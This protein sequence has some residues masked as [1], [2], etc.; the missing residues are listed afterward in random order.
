[1]LPVLVGNASANFIRN[2]WTSTVIFCGRF[3]DEAQTFSE[4]ECENESRGHWYYRQI[5]GSAN[6][7]GSR[8]LHI[9]SGHL[10]LQVEHHLFPDI[11]AHR[12]VEMAPLVEATA[13]KHG[14]PYNKKPFWTQY[15]T[16]VKRILQHSVPE[17][18]FGP[19]S[20]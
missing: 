2:I 13:R 7:D 15:K 4:E 14:I 6:F 10:S 19:V 11:P 18:F 9:M 12:Y 1:M 17:K 8:W 20:V 3:P 5:L 16:V